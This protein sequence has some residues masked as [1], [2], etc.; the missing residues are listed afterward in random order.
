MTDEEI[1]ESRRRAI[2]TAFKDGELRLAFF[3]LAESLG[4][5]SVAAQADPQMMAFHQGRRAGAKAMLDLLATADPLLPSR[6]AF[7]FDQFHEERK[8]SQPEE[9]EIDDG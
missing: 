7:E 4:Y 2:E 9:S 6:M 1:R 3:D 5:R 8:R